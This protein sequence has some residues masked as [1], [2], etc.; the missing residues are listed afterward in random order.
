MKS[1]IKP[2]ITRKPGSK[3]HGPKWPKWGGVISTCDSL[4]NTF[5]SKWPCLSLTS[6]SK[7]TT[8]KHGPWTHSL[9]HEPTHQESSAIYDNVFYD[10]DFYERRHNLSVWSFWTVSLR[11]TTCNRSAHTQKKKMV[12]PEAPTVSY[13]ALFARTQNI[14]SCSRLSDLFLPVLVVMVMMN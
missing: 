1:S 4:R 2:N 3:L 10:H 6:R 11:P 13:I 14:T 9:A 5:V 7:C 8:R 12:R